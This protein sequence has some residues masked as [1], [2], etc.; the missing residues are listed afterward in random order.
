MNLSKPIALA[1][2]LS[3]SSVALAGGTHG[4]SHGHGSAIGE[5]GKASE[6]SRTITVELYDNYY[7]PES[8][9]VRAGETVRFVVENKGNLVHEFNIGTPSMHEAHQEE[10]M[11]MVEHGVIQGGKLNHHMMEMDMGN[12]HTMKHDDP[13]SVLLEPGKSQEIIW[14]FSNEGNIEFACNVPG[15][16]QAGMY[17]EIQFM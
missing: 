15:H 5:P 6:A 10:M 2:A 9:E 17:G 16:Y 7:E 11:M 3:M 13:N 14:K 4:D 1:A 8:I 12:G